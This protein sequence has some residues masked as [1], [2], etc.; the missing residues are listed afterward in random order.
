MLPGI[1][2][3]PL[4]VVAYSGIIDSEQKSNSE[5]ALQNTAM[6]LA[7]NARQNTASDEGLSFSK[8]SASVLLVDKEG[9]VLYKG[10]GL[11]QGK[12]N[13]AEIE[14]LAMLLRDAGATQQDNES[15]KDFIKRE[16]ER[17]L[18]KNECRL[19][20]FTERAPCLDRDGCNKFLNEMF[21]RGVN[22]SV[23]HA[24]PRV[25]NAGRTRFDWETVTLAML[26]PRAIGTLKTESPPPKLERC[27]QAT[28]EYQD[29]TRPTDL[30]FSEDPTKYVREMKLGEIPLIMHKSE[31]AVK[32][33]LRGLL[34]NISEGGRAARQE[35]AAEKLRQ[36]SQQQMQNATTTPID[37]ANTTAAIAATSTTPTA[38]ATAGT[39][40]TAGTATGNTTTAM[41]TAVAPVIP[42]KKDTL[43]KEASQ[44]TPPPTAS[45]NVPDSSLP[46]TV[47]D[48][49]EAIQA[50]KRFMTESETIAQ[51]LVIKN[52]AKSLQ[53]TKIDEPPTI[54]KAIGEILNRHR[55]NRIR[56]AIITAIQE[57][58]SNPTGGSRQAAIAPV[59]PVIPKQAIGKKEVY[60]P[61]PPQLPQSPSVPP[62]IATTSPAT[63]ATTVRQAT[64][65]ARA[66]TGA[67]AVGTG[68]QSLQPSIVER[69]AAVTPLL[70]ASRLQTPARS[71]KGINPEGINPDLIRRNQNTPPLLALAQSSV[72][73]PL[74]ASPI[75]P[76]APLP[77]PDS[78]PSILRGA[79]ETPNRRVPPRSE[80]PPRVPPKRK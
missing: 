40:T 41:Q 77:L 7:L 1:P 12:Q 9:D 27:I 26:L 28:I 58:K 6:R 45:A 3:Y 29:V 55:Y 61:L 50:M 20:L 10:F 33:T 4:A 25:T 80:P 72:K 17:L 11:S 66:P 42:E 19:I 71:D 57:N 56:T 79:P 64:A 54:A 76:P 78:P 23:Y 38:G 70:G 59:A 67:S 60:Q 22:V 75:V 48:L 5:A 2:T 39:M 37:I 32:L 8:N 44:Q 65:P 74:P 68:M 53:I 21:S 49:I 46:P 13:H 73:P 15:G 24:I 14:A 34:H 62:A 51:L 16:E 52:L 69:L 35:K 47:K 43:Q 63:V 30:R 36:Q 18:K 31:G